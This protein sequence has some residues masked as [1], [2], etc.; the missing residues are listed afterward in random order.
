MMTTMAALFGAI[1]IALGYGA[2]G[3]A[4][5][6]L[7]LAVVGGLM[8]S[9]LVTLYLTPVF[10]TYMAALQTKLGKGKKPRTIAREPEPVATGD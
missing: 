2:G 5:Q 4:R 8:F 7:G 6:P 3:E 10:Y 1:P 9:Q